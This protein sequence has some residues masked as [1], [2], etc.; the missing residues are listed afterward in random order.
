M[1]HLTIQYS[2]QL[3]KDYNIELL[4][5]G[6]RDIMS[7]CNIFPVGGIRVRAWSTKYN[8]IADG[9]KKNRY[10][11]LILRMGIGRTLE[12]KKIIGNEIIEFLKI[13]FSSEIKN[14]YFALALE[15][16]EINNELSWK[17]NTIHDRLNSNG[18]N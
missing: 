18:Q 15:I 7:K 8:S 16:I 1:A 4:T 14:N 3:E 12:E 13:F 17:L 10:V 9:N 6:L 2:I 11:D 5:E